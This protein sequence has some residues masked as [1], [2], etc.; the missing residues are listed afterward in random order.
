[1]DEK[2]FRV[3][4]DIDAVVQK[5]LEAQGGTGFQFMGFLPDRDPNAAGYEVADLGRVFVKFRIGFYL[6]ARPAGR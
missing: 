2:E 4:P 3:L 6:R 1:M 5:R